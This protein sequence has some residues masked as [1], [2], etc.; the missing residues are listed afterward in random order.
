MN[1]L[2]KILFVVASMTFVTWLKWPGRK[3]SPVSRRRHIGPLAVAILMS[4]D[5]HTVLI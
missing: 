5:L 1:E 4:A 3:T 2:L